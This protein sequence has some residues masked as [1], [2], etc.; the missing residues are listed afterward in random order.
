MVFEALHLV[1]PGFS[2]ISL[3]SPQGPVL[4]AG[5]RGKLS[6]GRV[7]ALWLP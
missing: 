4:G 2:A 3:L 6:L 5:P 1:C 7:Q